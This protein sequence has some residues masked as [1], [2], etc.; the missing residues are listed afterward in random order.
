MAFSAADEEKSITPIT[1]VIVYLRTAI[2]YL[3]THSHSNV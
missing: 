1:S 3:K 2:D